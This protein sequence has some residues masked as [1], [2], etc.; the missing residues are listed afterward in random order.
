MGATYLRYGF[1]RVDVGVGVGLSL[2]SERRKRDP[3]S[4]LKVES[5]VWSVLWSVLSSVPWSDLRSIDIIMAQLCFVSFYVDR[6][7]SSW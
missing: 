3:R 2:L 5:Y 7:W 4:W 6:A 1:A